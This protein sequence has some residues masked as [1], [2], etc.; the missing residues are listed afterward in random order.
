[1]ARHDFINALKRVISYRLKKQTSLCRCSGCYN[2]KQKRLGK[3]ANA[4]VR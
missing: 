4:G 1:M 3:I 2:E